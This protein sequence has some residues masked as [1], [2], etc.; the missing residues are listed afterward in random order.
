MSKFDNYVKQIELNDLILESSNTFMYSLPENRKQRLFDFYTF[1]SLSP[2]VNKIQ[3]S[4]ITQVKS[5]SE[6]EVSYRGIRKLNENFVNSFWIANDKCY[7]ELAK[8]ML[9]DMFYCISAE[10]KHINQD[11][12]Y[13]DIYKVP[14]G[15]GRDIYSE[16]ISDNQQKANISAMNISPKKGEETNTTYNT[17][18]EKTIKAIAAAGGSIFDFAK[19]CSYVYDNFR[20]NSGYGGP[21]WA[22]AA[23]AFIAIANAIPKKYQPDFIFKPIKPANPVQDLTNS[24]TENPA[25]EKPKTEIKS[26]TD[27]YIKKEFNSLKPL[28][29]EIKTKIKEYHKKIYDILF[30]DYYNKLYRDIYNAIINIIPLETST[31]DDQNGD[32][33]DHILD[34]QDEL[35]K[36]FE[37]YKI[38]EIKSSTNLLVHSIAYITLNYDSPVLI[39]N[40]IRDI[41]GTLKGKPKLL[42]DIKEIIEAYRP[43]LDKIFKHEKPQED[44]EEPEEEPESEQSQSTEIYELTP[45]E[46]LQLFVAIDHAWGLS[47]N[48]GP[49]FNKLHSFNLLSPDKRGDW[50][51][52]SLDKRTQ[53]ENLFRFISSKKNE[54]DVSQQMIS[55]IKRIIYS[56]YGATNEEQLYKY[57]AKTNPIKIIPKNISDRVYRGIICKGNSIIAPNTY[58]KQ[59]PYVKFDSHFSY[60]CSLRIETRLKHN[61]EDCIL[62][63]HFDD[64]SITILATDKVNFSFNR[65]GI[66][67]DGEYIKVKINHDF[68]KS[69]IRVDIGVIYSKTLSQVIDKIKKFD[70]LKINP[71]KT[72]VMAS[73]WLNKGENKETIKNKLNFNSDITFARIFEYGDDL[74]SANSNTKIQL[75][76][77]GLDFIISRS[78][79]TFI[80]VSKPIET[81]NEIYG[82]PDSEEYF[83]DK[84]K[85][86]APNP[87]KPKIRFSLVGDPN[88]QKT[89]EFNDDVSANIK[90][91]VYGY[92]SKINDDPYDELNKLKKCVVEDFELGVSKIDNT[93]NTSESIRNNI[94]KEY[95]KLFPNVRS[96]YNNNT[97]RDEIL[98]SGT[99]HLYSFVVTTDK[100]R[101]TNPYSIILSNGNESITNKIYRFSSI[102]YIVKTFTDIMKTMIDD[103]KDSEIDG[104]SEALGNITSVKFIIDNYIKN[105]ST[106]PEKTKQMITAIIG[107]HDID[108]Y[109]NYIHQILKVVNSLINK[110]SDIIKSYKAKI[111]TYNREFICNLTINDNFKFV[112]IISKN[113]KNKMKFIIGNEQH[114]KYVYDVSIPIII[115]DALQQLRIATKGSDQTITQPENP[116]S[117]AHTTNKIITFETLVNQIHDI[118]LKKYLIGIFDYI[119]SKNFNINVDDYSENIID[120]FSYCYTFMPKSERL[121]FE[122]IRSS[123]LNDTY[124]TTTFNLFMGAIEIRFRIKPDNSTYNN[125]I[126]IFYKKQD[127]LSLFKKLHI[128]KNISTNN[129][130]IIKLNNDLTSIVNEL[131]T[132]HFLNDSFTIKELLK[133]F[134]LKG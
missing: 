52:T 132:K 2:L 7:I 86:P 64:H 118:N 60:W 98:I 94:P 41:G 96:V 128:P 114:T 113:D 90:D 40:Y 75:G 74:S 62:A 100:Q 66:N 107:N 22:D 31:P 23:N 49:T 92:V 126:A 28:P 15:F 61:D 133:S 80:S 91:L 130:E 30:G 13:T 63:C 45:K 77:D 12:D 47:H 4:E 78:M 42:M 35:T 127:M 109:M 59:P 14:S 123:M 9:N 79:I 125:E 58:F 29:K 70:G 19:L 99:N 38:H 104:F 8:E 95:S 88:I 57:V 55:I 10:F 1:S 69:D 124:I 51:I 110:G 112:F 54:S 36:A 32:Y 76:D 39:F 82:S 26:D 46:R 111:A 97:S 16:Y 44:A 11:P 25:H 101:L 72:R 53:D 56:Y 50:L 3:S 120:V 117:Q 27:K 73:L 84:R 24:N 33:I 71:N 17:R 68:Y 20:F 116:S 106:H 129:K 87:E 81:S 34:L 85:K 115:D 43:L 37:E 67:D 108:K 93:Y 89:F 21:Q 18:Y 103:I 105:F 131:K 48:T 83:A 121:H 5:A 102:E 122:L 134:L 119:K 6:D 65:D